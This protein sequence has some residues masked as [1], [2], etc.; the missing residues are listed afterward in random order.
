MRP[1]LPPVVRALRW[2]PAR[3]AV[4]VLFG[5][6]LAGLGNQSGGLSWRGEWAWTLDWVGGTVMLLGPVVAGL[7]AWRAV[8]VQRTLG[9]QVDVM[10]RPGRATLAELLGLVGWAWLCHALALVLA[11]VLTVQAGA[12]GLPELAPLLP[13]FLMLAAFAGLGAL[14]GTAVPSMLL[15]PFTTIGL[16]VAT[17]QFASG[18]LPSLWVSVGGAT[19]SLAGLRYRPDVLRWQL[20]LCLAVVALALAVRRS[21]PARGALVV[22]PAGYLALS[23]VVVAAGWLATTEQSRVEPSR[24]RVALTCMGSGP[25]VCVRPESRAA[26]RPVQKVLATLEDTARAAGVPDLPGRFAQVVADDPNPEGARGFVL[27][28]GAVQGSTA[29]PTLLARYLVVDRACLGGEHAP[30]ALAVG[31]LQ[32]AEQLLLVRAGAVAPRQ[33][34]DAALHA[35][36][37]SPAAAQGRWLQ[38][39]FA[40]GASCAF[41]AVPPPPAGQ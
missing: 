18:T 23:G 40:A 8:E 16:L 32:V 31:R 2:S 41:H 17:T 12:S 20:L 15:P 22:Q 19:S 4:P 9:E 6:E 38:A 3:Y 13:Q 28:P 25:E 24:E 37:G 27:N 30:D 10:P 36:L 7:A 1:A 34:A 35:A 26:A 21:G 14:L 29:D 33:V 39:A 5:I 11:A